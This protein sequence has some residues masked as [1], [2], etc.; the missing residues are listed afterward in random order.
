[1]KNVSRIEWKFL[2]PA[3]DLM[4]ICCGGQAGF[5]AKIDEAYYPGLFQL[6]VCETCGNLGETELLKKAMEG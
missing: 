1:M 3:P 6:P 4:C 2:N 5:I